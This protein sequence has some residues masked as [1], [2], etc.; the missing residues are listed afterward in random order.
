MRSEIAESELCYSPRSKRSWNCWIIFFDDASEHKKI[1][2]CYFWELGLV[3]LVRKS[4]PGF[5]R[6]LAYMVLTQHWAPFL[7]Y[8]LKVTLESWSPN[9]NS[10]LDWKMVVH[11]ESC[12]TWITKQTLLSF[13][14]QTR[15]KSAIYPTATDILTN[16]IR[17]QIPLD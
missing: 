3:G 17:L 10:I 16:V 2:F 12:E 1:I 6:L 13:I 5:F 11:F 7:F 15:Q 4:G 9:L 14:H 8:S